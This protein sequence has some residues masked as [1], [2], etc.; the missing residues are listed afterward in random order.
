MVIGIVA[1]DSAAT[2]SVNFSEVPGLGTGTFSWTEFYSGR[3]GSGTSVS[4]TLGLHDMAVI[5]VTT[6]GGGSSSTT[7]SVKS[8]TTTLATSTTASAGATQTHWGQCGGQGWTGPT[9]VL[10]RQIMLD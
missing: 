9:K 1:A 4:F 5:K 3:T 8:T 6:S 7:T 2:L 10:S